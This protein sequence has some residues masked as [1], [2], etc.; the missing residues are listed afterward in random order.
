MRTF[1]LTLACFVFSY[2]PLSAGKERSI[3]AL[4]N[5]IDKN[6]LTELFAFYHLYPNTTYA[7]LSYE[8]GWD[9]I[10]KHRIEKIEPHKD[11][12]IA[13][14]SINPLIS[15]L[16]KQRDS[17][18]ETLEPWYLN[19]LEKISDHLKHHKLKGHSLWTVEETEALKPEEIDL[20]RAILLKQYGPEK[21]D[22]I[23]RYEAEIDMMALQVLS[24]VPPDATPREKMLAINEF[25]FHEMRFRFPP[26][27]MWAKDVDLYTFLPSVLDSRHGVCLGVS[28]LYLSIAQRMGL[29][30]EIVTPPGHIYVALNENGKI[31]NIETTARGVHYP[32]ETYLGIHTKENDIRNMKEVVGLYFLNAAATAW[33]NEDYNKAIEFYLS[34]SPYLPNDPLLNTFLGFNYLFIGNKEEGER[35]LKK[36]LEVKKKD[37]L[38]PDTL[39][40]DYFAENVSI[41]GIKAVYASVDETRESILEKQAKVQTILKSEPKFREGYFHL[42]VTWFQIGRTKEAKECLEKYHALD[43]TNP[44]VEYYLSI[45]CMERYEFKKAKRHYRNLKVILDRNNHN[46]K[47]LIELRQQLQQKAPMS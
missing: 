46:P 3:E 37:E 32:T 17:E 4:Y 28:I 36:V 24:R 5:S 30:L 25:I 45:L 16:T 20:T 13:L 26:H 6:S 10:N 18:L 39:I 27:S 41:E 23:R 42:A 35:R 7:T 15:L 44:T 11:F 38:S 12:R 1:I 14:F 43:P 2:F 8:K 21:R 19:T 33:Q 31:T 29:E 47:A 34:G 40:E 9:L 22:L